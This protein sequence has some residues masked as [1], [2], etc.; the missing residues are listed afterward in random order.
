ME[1]DPIATKYGW[2][3][4]ALRRR[5]AVTRADLVAFSGLSR[6]T[7]TERLDALTAAGLIRPSGS[8]ASNGGRPAGALVLDPA[9][10]VL[11]A[12]EVN[13]TR[14]DVAFG[15]IDGTLEKTESLPIKVS[16]GPE[17]V[18]HAVR[19]C[20]QRLIRAS[21]LHE[22]DVRGIGIGLP[23][24]IEF[25]KGR[26]VQPPGMP[27]WDDVIVPDAF[28]SHFDCRVLV[29]NEVNLMAIGEQRI[30]WPEV[31]DLLF[32]TCSTGVGSGLI[33]GG[34]LQRGANGGAGEIGH[35]SMAGLLPGEPPMCR[36]GSRGCLE[37]YASGWRLVESLRAAG[38]KVSVPADVALLARQGDNEALEALRSAAETIGLALAHAV[39][40]FNPAMLV[41]G[42]DLLLHQDHVLAV[43]KETV[44]RRAVP[45]ATRDL[46]IVSSRLGTEAGLHGG[47]QLLIDELLAPASVDRLV[48]AAGVRPSF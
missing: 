28:A 46:R 12:A 17:R 43:I 38:R 45:L 40:L 1:R 20:M 19:T 2:L 11:L 9:W 30:A 4:S 48:A 41:I 18:L 14:V 37:A 13:S 31:A 7:I 42:G 39:S 36:C 23:G 25:A 10:G 29:D 34:A 27:G 24:P 47:V 8:A 35:G 16:E 5:Q 6:T 3:V 15:R 33:A 21:G 26:A 44:I 32:V 22:R